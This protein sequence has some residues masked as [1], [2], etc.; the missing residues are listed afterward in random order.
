MDR[1]R[2]GQDSGIRSSSR[3][4]RPSR[5]GSRRKSSSS[6]RS[7]TSTDARPADPISPAVRHYPA[8]STPTF[9]ASLSG[10]TPT[11]IKC[12]APL[13]LAR[14]LASPPHRRG[15]LDADVIQASASQPGCRRTA[16][17]R[18]PLGTAT[19][20]SVRSYSY[21][22][23]FRLAGSAIEAHLPFFRSRTPERAAP[24]AAPIVPSFLRIFWIEGP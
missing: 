20:E 7:S 14:R 2:T 10:L 8:A 3:T 13:S 23:P 24:H 18:P 1:S 5:D 6:S 9:T 22:S 4:S 17:R 21:S 19:P 11:L 12:L 16:E 15:R